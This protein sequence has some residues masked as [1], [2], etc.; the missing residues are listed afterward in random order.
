MI[1]LFV[2]TLVLTVQVSLAYSSDG[3][4]MAGMAREAD[5]DY[6]LSGEKQRLRADKS[7]EAERYFLYQQTGI[8]LKVLSLT[9][10]AF[11]K[12][13]LE[14]GSV[15]EV[16]SQDIE[17]LFSWYPNDSVVIIPVLSWKYPYDYRLLNQNN[18]SFVHV[19]LKAV[20][21]K[22]NKK[23]YKLRG[24]DLGSGMIYLDNSS[25]LQVNALDVAILEG[26]ELNDPIL[27]G[28]NTSNDWQDFSRLLIN[29]R[30]MND[31]RAERLR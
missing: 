30:C 11:P 16:A 28:G 3:Y 17:K 24:M 20:P 21:L 22:A 25:S 6:I 23:C 18:L 15:W 4:I 29:V 8:E 7:E 26:W 1:K 2:L 14:D 12:L 10:G 27:I 13:E 31:V 9:H 5:P 19:S